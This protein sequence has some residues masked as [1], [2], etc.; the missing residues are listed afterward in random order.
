MID[1]YIIYYGIG[2]IA[3][4]IT[5]G[6]QA[7]V[8][9]TFNKY[10]K[11]K[12]NCGKT[13]AEVAREIL[14][15]NNLSDIYV[16]E[17]KGV[18][19]DHYD[20]SRKVIRLSKDV[21]NMESIGALAVAAHECGHAIQDKDNYKFLRI[22]SKLVPIVT[23]ASYAGYI[24]IIIGAI[25]SAYNIIWAGILLEAMIIV[26]QLVTLPVE[27][28]ASKRALKELEHDHFLDPVELPQ[29]KMVL[30]SAALTY[31]ASLAT[32]IL[33]ILRLILIYGNRRD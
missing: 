31:V 5:I 7:F 13:G 32:A 21:Y 22:R 28:D 27:V 9:L 12:N 29:A 18:L 10:K 23:F 1:N 8:S 14:D 2:A 15:K 26:F 25:M 30:T 16:V 20:P 11:V 3:L 19:S 17:T 24:S 4:L 6:A 33:E